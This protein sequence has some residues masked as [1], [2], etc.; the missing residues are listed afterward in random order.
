MEEKIEVTRSE[1]VAVFTA[2]NEHLRN[3]PDAFDAE[4]DSVDPAPQQDYEQRQADHFLLLHRE[5]TNARTA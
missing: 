3:E 5:V 4:P 2:W 1:I